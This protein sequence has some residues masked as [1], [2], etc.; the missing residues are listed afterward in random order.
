M[1]KSTVPT[2]AKAATSRGGVASAS[3]RKTSRSGRS[4]RTALFQLR[5]SSSSQ[6]PLLG[7]RRTMR[8]TSGAGSPSTLAVGAGRPPGTCALARPPGTCTPSTL[9]T[10]RAGSAVTDRAL[11][12][13]RGLIA[14]L[15]DRRIDRRAVGRRG[16]RARRVAEELEDRERRAAERGAEMRRHRRRRPARAASPAWSAPAP[17]RRAGSGRRVRW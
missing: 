14:G 13:R 12:H 4:N 2:C 5:P 15:E 8:L 16:E 10:A 1:L 11:G 7:L 17:P 3:M 6:M 9:H